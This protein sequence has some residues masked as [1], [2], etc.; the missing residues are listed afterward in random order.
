[1]EE[2][3]WSNNKNDLRSFD[4]ILKTATDNAQKMDFPI[5]ISLVNV[6]KSAILYGFGHIYWRNL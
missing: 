2:F 1:M 3:F 5:R 4:N 6:T